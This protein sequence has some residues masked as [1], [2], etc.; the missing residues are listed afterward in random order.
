MEIGGKYKDQMVTRCCPAGKWKFQMLNSTGASS[1][2]HFGWCEFWDFLDW[3]TL[4]PATEEMI[5]EAGEQ[6]KK[7]NEKKTPFPLSKG[8]WFK[9]LDKERIEEVNTLRRE[10]EDYLL[11]IEEVPDR[12]S[13]KPSS[14]PKSTKEELMEYFNRKYSKEREDK[15]RELWKE[16]IFNGHD[17]E[18]WKS[19][20]KEYDN[21]SKGK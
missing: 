6:E 4:K 1:C 15:L 19:L 13:L 21:L 5:R 16:G 10:L 12:L 3:R 20:Q 18:K 8:K 17:T 7:M 11:T 14:Q 9:Y 2:Q